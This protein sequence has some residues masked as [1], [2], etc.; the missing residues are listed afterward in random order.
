MVSIPPPPLIRAPK[1]ALTRLQEGKDES[2]IRA[3]GHRRAEACRRSGHTHIEAV[4][5]GLDDPT[6]LIQGLIENVVREDLGPLDTARALKILQD[7]TGWSTRDM[8]AQGFMSRGQVSRLLSLLD[9]SEEVQ[10]LLVTPAGVTI[11]DTSGA[12]TERHVREAR[13]SGLSETDRVTVLRKAARE[14]LT[15]AQTREGAD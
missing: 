6:A 11:G 4:V 9:E 3:L 1:N 8:A 10:Q 7:E 13:R 2:L 14:G 15:A 12:I 5:E